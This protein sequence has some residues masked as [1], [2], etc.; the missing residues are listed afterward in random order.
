M[1]TLENSPFLSELNQNDRFQSETRLEPETPFLETGFVSGSWLEKEAPSLAV[2]TF[3]EEVSQRIETPFITQYHGESPV[4]S[5]AK[6]IEQ[7]LMDMFDSEFNEA[8]AN[9]AMEAAAQAKQYSLTAGEEA[10]EV[11]L[12]EWLEPLRNASQQLFETVGE[13]AIQQ[14]L[15]GM[16]ESNLD[17]FFDQFFPQS[18][19]VPPQFEEFL[20]KV[21]K[22]LK[23]IGKAGW[24]LARQG[25]NAIGK[26]FPIGKLLKKLG[27]LV[28]PLLNKIIRF[29]I[30]KLPL[31]LRTAATVLGR[32]LGIL[33]EIE[34]EEEAWGGVPTTPEVESIAQDF[35]VSV[36]S[37]LLA[38]DEAQSELLLSEITQET[39]AETEVNTIYELDNAREH[40]VTKF[41]QLQTGENAGPLVQQFIPAILPLLRVGIRIVGRDKIVKFLANQ[42]AKLIRGL[43]GPK[44]ALPLSQGLMDLGLRLITLEINAEMEP[45][46]RLAAR[47]VAAT[48]EDSMRRIANYNLNQFDNLEGNIEQQKLLETI[49][50]ESFFEAAL[51]HFPPQLL[52]VKRLNEREMALENDTPNQQGVWAYLPNPKYKKYTHI[53]ES[54]LTQSIAE[55]II[56]FGDQ[57]LSSFLRARGVQLPRKFKI[58]L[59]E[60]IPG[61]TLSH[62]ALLEKHTH[63][64]GSGSEEAWSK[65]HPLTTQAAGLLLREPGLGRDMGAKWL[66]SRHQIAVGQ[67]F[68]YIEISTQPQGGV[69]F[70][71]R[72]SEVNI[73]I[74]LRASQVR[75][76]IYFSEA[77]SQ[78][79]VAA[80]PTAGPMTAM[81]I[82]QGMAVGVVN[83]ITSGPAKHLTIIREAAGEIE[84]EEFWQ[85]IA[86]KAAKEV[87]RWLLEELARVLLEMLKTALI[88]YFNSNLSAF[89][90]ATRAPT[91]GVTLIFTFN[92]PGLRVLH[93]VLAGRVPS[94][95][96]VRVAARAI[97]LPSATIVPGFTRK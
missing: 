7:T 39:P 79:I 53:F 31:S 3:E 58:H 75:A 80:G 48:I 93:A 97:Q 22:K 57:P 55:K 96:D 82:A 66:A 19:S 2:P 85:G 90:T 87:G 43:V 88:R 30:N 78:R 17:N 11:L 63:G 61:T 1:T 68:Y 13:A 54:S 44:L 23:D 47:T 83:S 86:G 32:K 4:N 76:N 38:H 77:D 84:G 34:S 89:A 21:V 60:S 73:T 27:K 91:D 20:N 51:A 59:Y 92:H 70:P 35:D 14:H 28:R 95:S 37:L 10:T 9:L 5:E 24:K 29:A 12:N 36:T 46:E 6:L 8:V 45:P 67:R 33:R 25:A 74:D 50:N 65:I 16:D 52:D 26:I 71:V 56:T 49:T 64:L 15:E 41:S 69:K 62:I 81:R 18:G 72:A 94:M 40:F 42:T